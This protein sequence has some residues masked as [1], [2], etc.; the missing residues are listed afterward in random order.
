MA[1]VVEDG[2]VVTGANS[3]VSVADAKA[4]IESRGRQFAADDVAIE[5]LLLRAMDYLGTYLSQWQGT[6]LDTAQPLPWPRSGV[7]VDGVDLPTSPLPIQ[8]VNAQSELAFNAET[9]TLQPTSDGRVVSKQKVD[10]IEVEYESNQGLPA[11]P[12]I[13]TVNTLI[14][15]L[16]V[17]SAGT[18]RTIRV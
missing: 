18:I 11:S 9:I 7:S 17:T 13:Q 14:Q 8:L 5:G 6:R 12:N 3:Y 2:T 10:V 4:Y 1:L 15:P 16:L